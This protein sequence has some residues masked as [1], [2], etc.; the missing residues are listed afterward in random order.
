[1]LIE[2]FKMPEVTISKCPHTSCMFF[3]FLALRLALKVYFY[4]EGRIVSLPRLKTIHIHI[5]Y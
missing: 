3:F 5:L 2:Y 1:M 4:R